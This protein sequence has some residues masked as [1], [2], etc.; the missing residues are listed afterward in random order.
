VQ[1]TPG[2]INT[3]INKMWPI[4]TRNSALKRKEILT[5]A[6]KWKNLE[7]IIKCYTSQSQW[8]RNEMTQLYQ[9]LSI[10]RL[11]RQKV[12]WWLPATVGEE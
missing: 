6:I 10:V 8:D 7:N 12:E 2:S 11:Q 4:H 3:E 9:V 5:H 1:A